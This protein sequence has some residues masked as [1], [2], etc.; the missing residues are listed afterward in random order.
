MLILLLVALGLWSAGF[1]LLGR[2]RPCARVSAAG[3]SP[4]VSVIIP[5]RNEEHNLPTLLRSLA[6]QSLKPQE[7]LVVDDG[8]TDRT[9]EVARQLGA[10]VMASQPLPDGWRGKTWACHQGAQAARGELLLFL[11]ADTWFEPDG[12][13]K[14]VSAYEGG[15]FSIGPYHAVRK[16]YEQ[17]SLFFNL[18]M[19]LATVPHGLFGQI[20]LVDRESYRR[21]GGHETV[22]GRVLENSWLAARFHAAGLPV[23][24]VTGKGLA[25]FR[26]YPNGLRELIEGWTKGFASGAGQTPRVPLL[27][28][29]AWIA[30]LMLAPL[31]GLVSS[32]WLR[33]GVLYLL[34]G[35]QVGWFSRRVGAFRWSSALLYPLPLL[36]FFGV[37]AWSVARSGRRVSWK[38]R[39][40][41]AD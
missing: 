30:G 10:T 17:L 36:F 31:G 33:W 37:F 12:L 7:I 25:S 21:V 4:N 39:E 18:N 11:D 6:S 1:L 34:C 22:Q 14:T 32:D 20:L 28:I 24:S 27:V 3:H 38:G 9:A 5:A 8:S 29:V 15:A 23:R 19:T 35:A 26:M 13:G 41:R 16:A 40:I 2:L